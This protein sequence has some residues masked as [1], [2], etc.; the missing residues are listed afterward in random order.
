MATS[1]STPSASAAS[2][3]L[4]GALVVECGQGV[5]A[6]FAAK[7][8]S[9]LGAEVIKIEP[10]QGDVAR[11]RGPFPDDRPDPDR[12]GLFMYLNANKLGVTADLKAATGRERLNTLLARADILIHN[13]LPPERAA[14]GLGGD[15]LAKTFPHLI[16]TSISPFADSGPRASYRAYE[17]NMIHAAAL[18]SCNMACLEPLV[19]A[20]KLVWEQVGFQR[21]RA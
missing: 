5:A 11:T 17:L 12:S 4:G 20:G 14:M 13:V 19:A 1:V 2:G 9:Q 21:G 15:A 18:P 6:S 8:L 7:L 10:P 16:R 3:P